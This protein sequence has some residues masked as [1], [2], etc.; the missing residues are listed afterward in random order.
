MDIDFVLKLI[1]IISISLAVI[2]L[3]AVLTREYVCWYWKTSE[4][5]SE[6]EKLNSKIDVLIEIE[7]SKLKYVE[8]K[9][10]Q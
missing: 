4:I 7:K 8:E 10:A 5:T 3:I 9:D 2:L 6:L 1:G